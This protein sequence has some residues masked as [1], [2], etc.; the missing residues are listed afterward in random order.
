MYTG[1]QALVRQE[2]RESRSQEVEMCL[3]RTTRE[4]TSKCSWD[5]G[6]LKNE[7]QFQRQEEWEIHC[8]PQQGH[9]RSREIQRNSALIYWLYS[10]K[11]ILK[12]MPATVHNRNKGVG[13]KRKNEGKG[14]RRADNCSSSTT[15]ASLVERKQEE[16]FR[17]G[18]SYNQEG[19]RRRVMA[20][21]QKWSGGDR[22]K[23][24][25]RTNDR[26]G[27]WSDESEMTL[28]FQ[29]LQWQGGQQ[30]DLKELWE[31]QQPDSGWGGLGAGLKES[32]YLKGFT[33]RG[34]RRVI[35]S[36]AIK[37]SSS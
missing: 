36:Q 13:E 10:C 15:E 31:K 30:C 12:W 26:L 8:K 18:L 6:V 33:S 19:L 11:T 34:A 16:A 5:G 7:E 24:G 1:Y 22:A 28:K 23:T 37:T 35:L 3:R 21:Q 17:T 29:A 14:E 32:S 4:V 25:Q 2:N 9:T 27:N 20:G